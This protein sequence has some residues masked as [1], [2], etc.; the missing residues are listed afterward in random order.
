[1][2]GTASLQRKKS[3]E[4]PA[5]QPSAGQVPFIAT[6]VVPP[7]ARASRIPRARLQELL[8]EATERKLTILRA[9]GGFGKTTLA[10]SWIEALRSQ[11]DAVAWLSV[12]SDD[13]EPRRFAYYVIHALHRACQQVGVESLKVANTAPMHQL[14][15]MLVNEIADF[16]DELYLFLDD[17][18][19]ISQ[20]SIHDFISFLLRHAPAN[21]RLVLLSRSEPPL[22][23]AALRARGELLEID[24]A[25]LRFTREETGEFLG[26]AT[27]A[28]LGSAEVRTIHGLTEG[29]PAA[30]RITALS[31]G[32]GRDPAELLRSLAG[33]PR[34]I[35]GF[36]DELCALLPAELL[37][38]MQLTSIVDRLSAPLCEAITGRSDSGE[39]LERLERQQL[40]SPLD[41][42]GRQFTCH[43]L[44]REYLAQ[45]LEQQRRDDVAGLRRAASRWYE[46]VGLESE[47]IK[48]LLAAGD[49]DAA[50]LRITQCAD[51]MVEAGDL[52]TLLNLQQQLRSKFIQQ[53][54]KLQI[55]IIWA[56]ALSLSAGDAL[57]HVSTVESAV[58]DLDD[59]EAKLAQ[60]E[61]LALR[62]VAAALADDPAGALELASGYG[63]QPQDRPLARDSVRNVTRFVY[64]AAARWDDFYA[65][66]DV[67]SQG[68]ADVMAATYAA[69]LCGIAAL[70]QAQAG[71]AEQHF[72]RSLVLGS[73]ARRFAGATAM[74]K[75]AYAELLYE[76]GRMAEAEGLLRDDLDLIAGGVTLDT[77][78]R[79]LRTAVRLAWRRGQLEQ[80]GALLERAEAI[81]LTR[82]WPRLVASALFERL[83]LQQQRGMSMASLGLLKRLQQISVDEAVRTVR[84]IEGVVHYL[85]MAQALVDLDQNRSRHAIGVL[86][87]LFTDATACGASLLALR[88][89]SLLARALVQA[90]SMPQAL[91]IFNHVLDL[92]EP[93]AL[94][95]SI[96]DT[97][98]EML[99]LVDLSD[100][101]IAGK[102]DERRQQLIRKLRE[103]AA[104]VWGGAGTENASGTGD[105][106][107]PLSPRECEILELIAAGASNKAVARDLGLGPE[108]VKTHLKNIFVKLEVERRTQAVLRAGE[109]GLLRVPRGLR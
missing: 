10:L 97:G 72:K 11:G 9:P 4:A 5:A 77:V 56:E 48:Q 8:A 88:L 51:H 83:R 2:S 57:R 70:S 6:K 34:S 35:G 75:G 37:D 85:K 65:V 22:E 19:A 98:P 58:R 13:N 100:N 52:L 90:R 32:A 29:W 36:L 33:S 73:Q 64:V 59:A 78:L 47:S 1:V 15:A 3:G 91:R 39:L 38:F 99:Q 94:V 7:V 46:S 68:G 24:A 44:F 28:N 103:S 106:P 63:P 82:D 41:E 40:L 109:L 71:L 105:L 89:G 18:N 45:R 53:P 108:T 101:S 93:S 25:K 84:G 96:A 50:L 14:Q 23:L 60:R 27:P 107:P 95:G 26:L 69:N 67:V 81:G 74:A 76:T 87:P 42:E 102:G 43:Q 92:A 62:A 16:G 79:G 17:Y 21:L 12:D 104:P 80:A 31:F 49:I 61:C 86:T 66:P 20:E 30:L 54:V 55:A